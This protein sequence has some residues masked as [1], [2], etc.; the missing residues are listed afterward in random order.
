MIRKAPFRRVSDRLIAYFSDKKTGVLATKQQTYNFTAGAIYGLR[1][2]AE[3]YAVKLAASAN[4][5]AINAGRVTLQSKDIDFI[6]ANCD[7]TFN[8]DVED[9]LLALR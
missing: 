6:R 8:K 9:T 4:R 2:A 5:A 7:T 3:A 1:Q